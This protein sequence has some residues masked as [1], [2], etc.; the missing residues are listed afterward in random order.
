MSQAERCRSK[1]SRAIRAAFPA[2]GVQREEEVCKYIDVTTCIGCKACEVA[3]VEWNDQPF[4][5]T[6]FDNTYQT[7]PATDVE[8]LEPDQVQ[9]AS[10]RRR[11]ADVADAQG[12]VHALRGPGLP[13]RVPGRRR[14]RPV[15]ERHRRLPA[16]EL[17]R[18][19]VLRH[20]AARST[21]RSSTRTTKK[22]YKCTLCSDRVGQGLEPACIKACPTGCLQF[23]TKDDMRALAETRAQQLREHSGFPNAGVYDPPSIGG[24]HVIYV[25]HD[26]T[27]PELYGGLPANPQIPPSLHGLEAVAKPIGLLLALLAAPVAFF[28]YVD[29]RAEGAAASR[30]RRRGAAMRPARRTIRRGGARAGSIAYGRTVVR[31]ASCCAIPSTRASLHWAVAIFFILS[32]LS[33][34]RHLLAVALPLADAALRRRADDAA[35]APLVQPRLRRRSSRLQ[36]LNWLRADDVDARRSAAGSG[37]SRRTSPIPR[38]SSRRT[39]ASS[40]AGR[41]CTSGRSS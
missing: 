10:A 30:P 12:P 16:G 8:L 37:A 4:R 14:H 11:H 27:K 21:S 41:S 25:L 24:T 3:C 35:A 2:R 23:G 28:H 5:E 7:M 29:R 26:T 17:H 38:S 31:A 18:L 33:G 34:L 13:A 15:H 22:V 36:F 19:P 39:S 9:R 1:R 20:R 6:T 40:T 32:L